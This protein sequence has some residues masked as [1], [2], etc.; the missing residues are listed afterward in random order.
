MI[1]GQPAAAWHVRFLPSRT[2]EEPG[3]GGIEH[4]HGGSAAVQLGRVDAPWRWSLPTDKWTTCRR[5]DRT[6]GAARRPRP[7][8]RL[9]SASDS[10]MCSSPW[11]RRTASSQA[12]RS[13]RPSPF[14]AAVSGRPNSTPMPIVM[15]TRGARL[16][17]VPPSAAPPMRAGREGADL[18]GAGERK[19]DHPSAVARGRWG[20]ARRGGTRRR[21][22][23]SCS[24]PYHLEHSLRIFAVGTHPCRLFQ[25]GR[26]LGG[27][28]RALVYLAAHN[29]NVHA[30]RIRGR[31]AVG[32][33]QRPRG[34][35]CAGAP[36]APAV[37]ISA[38]K[39]RERGPRKRGKRP[40]HLPS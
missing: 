22:R 24:A 39:I 5:S 1:R 25:L 26:R 29:V 14:S 18:C 21:L 16:P 33:R 27:P 37:G 28:P 32:R 38:A 35:P 6:A 30:A 19:G 12:A 17:P 7:A 2:G 11:P 4:V 9:T 8:R 20:T 34:G 15:A 10:A 13:G 31:G 3:R 36:W 40:L 23:V